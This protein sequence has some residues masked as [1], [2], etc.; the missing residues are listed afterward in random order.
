LLVQFAR[1]LAAAVRE[2][3]TVCRQGG[4]EFVV[5]L[6]GLPDDEQAR[7]VAHKVLAVCSE[8]FVLQ[9]Q[10]LRVG[11]SAG[12]A[13]FPQ[14]GSSYDELA[15]NADAAMY[16]AKRSGRMQ[17]RRYVGPVADPEILAPLEAQDSAA[18]SER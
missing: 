13:L 14:H 15:R 7:V 2:S 17:V 12:M 6:P 1:R 5:L 4:D 18:L 9:G 8:P 3:D 10:A 11:L 16:A